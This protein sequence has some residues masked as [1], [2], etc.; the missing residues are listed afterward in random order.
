MEAARD[1]KA[2]LLDAGLS[3]GTKGV[4]V[5]L[6]GLADAEDVDGGSE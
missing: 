4:G 3:E 1:S 5:Y 2:A 6:G